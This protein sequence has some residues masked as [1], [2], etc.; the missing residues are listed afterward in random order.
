VSDSTAPGMDD[1]RARSHGVL[2]VIDSVSPKG[3]AWIRRQRATVTVTDY[4]SCVCD[5]A[6]GVDLL[7]SA[8][9]KGLQV[10]DLNTGERA[11]LV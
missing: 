11:L 6:T 4:G 7:F 2:M 1:L 3:L 10:R 9:S 5:H 8:L